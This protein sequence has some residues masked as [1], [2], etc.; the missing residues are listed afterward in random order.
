MPL[1]DANGKQLAPCVVSKA[2]HALNI[3]NGYNGNIKRFS[4]DYWIKTV[5]VVAKYHRLSQTQINAAI[6]NYNH[7]LNPV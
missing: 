6:N 1:L 2:K 3:P 5:N 7:Y 4:L